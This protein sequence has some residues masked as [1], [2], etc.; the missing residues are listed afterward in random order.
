MWFPFPREWGGKGTREEEEV[1]TEVF[2][3]D[4]S[5][6]VRV[7]QNLPYLPSDCCGNMFSKCA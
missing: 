5:V 2:H 3:R 7:L 4:I 6:F 1:S